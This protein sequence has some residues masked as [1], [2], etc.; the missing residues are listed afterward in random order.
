MRRARSV[1]VVAT[2][3]MSTFL[4]EVTSGNYQLTSQSE[5]LSHLQVATCYLSLLNGLE[6]DGGV[7]ANRP[8]VISQHRG[9]AGAAVL[10]V[11]ARPS[12]L[13]YVSVRRR[14]E[15]FRKRSGD[16]IRSEVDPQQ[17]LLR[18]PL[19]KVMQHERLRGQ[20]RAV[21]AARVLF[22]KRTI[23]AAHRDQILVQPPVVH[24]RVVLPPVE[25][26]ALE[27]ARI[28]RRRQFSLHL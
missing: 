6:D 7:S 19:E 1:S 28:V 20:H 13:P 25:D 5:S 24:V 21:N 9:R 23:A 12:H 4:V 14:Q 15:R 26:R 27:R 22:G 18:R 10:R 11:F 17:P 3:A 16:E 8:P 2:T